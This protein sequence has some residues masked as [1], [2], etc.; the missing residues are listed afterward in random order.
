VSQRALQA[1]GKL[2]EAGERGN[3]AVKVEE[4]KQQP[5]EARCGLVVALRMAACGA[6]QLHFLE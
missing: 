4:G 3:Q 2:H 5:L 1:Q 6:V